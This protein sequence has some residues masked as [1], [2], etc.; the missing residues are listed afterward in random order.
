MINLSSGIAKFVENVQLCFVATVNPDGTPNLSPKGSLAVFD[1]RHLVFANIASP[2]TIANLRRDPRVAINVVDMFTRRGYGFDGVAE[3]KLEGTPEY[4]FVADPLWAEHSKAYPV[5]QVL[6]VAVHN[7]REVR[8][9][10]YTFGE[11][12]TEAGLSEAFQ[13]TYADRAAEVSHD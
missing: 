3:I 5:H 13:K 2:N 10:A 12:V 7:V 9:P 8:S 6:K 4:A 11:G 1:T